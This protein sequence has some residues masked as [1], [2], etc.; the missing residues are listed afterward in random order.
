M[1]RLAGVVDVVGCLLGRAGTTETEGMDEVRFAPVSSGEVAYRVVGG[2]G[3]GIIYATFGTDPIEVQDE[4]PWYRRFLHGLT[5]LGCVVSIDRRGVGQSDAPDWDAPVS[6]QWVEDILAV[7]DAEGLEDV[8]IVYFLDLVLPLLAAARDP[9]RIRRVIVLSPVAVFASDPVL[10]QR[11]DRYRIQQS[12]LERNSDEFAD[13]LAPVRSEDPVFKSWYRRAGRLGST[14]T[15]AQRAFEA[16]AQDIE[17]HWPAIAQE[18]Y[19][20]VLLVHQD[21]DIFGVDEVVIADITRQI[22]T[23]TSV[24]IP[25]VGGAPYSTEPTPLLGEIASFLGA[26]PITSPERALRAILFTDIVDSTGRAVRHGDERWRQVL[27]AHDHTAAEVVKRYGGHLTKLTGDGLLAA[28]PTGSLALDAVIHL[29][30]ALEEIGLQ[31]RAGVHVGEIEERG[32]D[33]GGIAVHVAA[34]VMGTAGAGDVLVTNSA[35]ESVLGGKH[36][37]A[38]AGDH[39]LKGVPGRW[40]LH[41][42]KR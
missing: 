38:V 18:I 34:R 39:A 42:L 36:D 1:P 31:V 9:H 27:D 15:V 22:P 30:V 33:V 10:R 35:R 4:D 23:A 16:R 8:T 25:G 32:D 37:F 11:F 3:P 41:R 7:A 20:D 13:L 6:E 24:R 2:E 28:F 17:R 12:V 19:A 5:A 40:R 26:G 29:S 14:G 21:S